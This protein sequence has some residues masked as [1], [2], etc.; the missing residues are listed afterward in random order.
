M[1][2]YYNFSMSNNAVD[3]YECGEM[4]LSKWS[5]ADIIA[6]IDRDMVNDDKIALIKKAPLKACKRLLTQSSWHHTSLY[7]NHTNFYTVDNDRLEEISIDDLKDLLK[8]E[9]KEDQKEFKVI[10]HYLEWSGTRKHPKATDHID[11]GIIKGNWFYLPNGKKK[12]IKATG[13]EII[14]KL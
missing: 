10:A 11:E 14:Q 13:F 12:S 5:K 7:Y 3:A 6:A 9:K 8:D 2:G 4:P 1:A